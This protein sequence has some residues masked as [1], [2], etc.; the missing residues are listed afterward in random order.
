MLVEVAMSTVRPR[1]RLNVQCQVL[2]VFWERPVDGFEE[3][4]VRQ[5]QV[6]RG[7]RDVGMAH[8]ALDDVYVLT[9]THEAR[10]V[11]VPPAVWVVP[12]GHTR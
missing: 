9:P 2:S 7:R 11:G 10:G 4:R 3:V 1:V 5:V 8:E 6:P 12:A